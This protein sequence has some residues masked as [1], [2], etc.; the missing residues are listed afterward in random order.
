MSTQLLERVT[1]AF[2]VNLSLSD[3]LFSFH[4]FLMN[5]TLVTVSNNNESERAAV[6]ILMN[7]SCSSVYIQIT[8][9]L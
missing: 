7:C 9:K 1:Y 3:S 5:N 2:I 6:V 4:A 8:S